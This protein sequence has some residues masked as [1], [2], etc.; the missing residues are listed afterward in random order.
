MDKLFSKRDIQK[1][2]IRGVNWIGDT[3]ITIPTIHAIRTVFPNAYLAILLKT[4]LAQL[5]KRY[6]FVDE[7]LFYPEG[8]GFELF[9]KEVKLVETLRTKR[10]DLAATPI[11]PLS[12]CLTSSVSSEAR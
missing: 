10:F 9:K 4:H 7:L 12:S 3:I 1:I 2:L 11:R 5:F 6:T 8:R